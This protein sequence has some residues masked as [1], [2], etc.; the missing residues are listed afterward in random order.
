MR[1]LYDT[2]PDEPGMMS[3]KCPNCKTEVSEDDTVY[4]IEGNIV[5]CEYC[6]FEKL[7][8]EVNCS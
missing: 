6:V 2:G 8:Y 1:N 4:V 7:L 5:G 3:I